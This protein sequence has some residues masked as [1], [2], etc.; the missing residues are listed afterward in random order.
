MLNASNLS[1]RQH[2][3]FKIIGKPVV[4][5]LSVDNGFH[6]DMYERGVKEGYL[7]TCCGER[8]HTFR[9]VD[10]SEMV[11]ECGRMMD[12]IAF[13][14]AEEIRQSGLPLP[15]GVERQYTGSLIHSSLLNGTL[16]YVEADGKNGKSSFYATKHMGIVHALKNDLAESEKR[17][18]VEGYHDQLTTSH[19]ELSSNIF[20]VIKIVN[21]RDGFKLSKHRLNLNRKGIVMMPMYSIGNYIDKLI[22]CLTHHRVLMTY[23]EEGVGYQ[24]V[25]SLRT[26]AIAKWQQSNH[27]ATIQK[28]QDSWQ[29][30]FDFGE[31]ILPNLLIPNQYVKVRV[32]DIISI[33][34]L[35]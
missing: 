14:S 13:Y 26:D 1:Q 21:D 24:F 2:E 34:K 18:K 3:Y 23:L 8:Q 7:I 31:I 16:C 12:G 6:R 30:P 28:V 19:Q 15:I 25:T 10:I 5:A 29:N 9:S 20:N 35:D 32:L 4:P 11:T 27:A 17:K 33:Q 22:Y